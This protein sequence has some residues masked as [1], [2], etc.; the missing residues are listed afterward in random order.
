MAEE[1]KVI[2]KEGVCYCRAI[3]AIVIII[4][5][6]TMQDPRILVTI[7]AALIVLGSGGCMCRK[8]GL[9]K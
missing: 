7:L 6:W 8:K 4:L 1:K 3:A 2:P 5:V 9:V